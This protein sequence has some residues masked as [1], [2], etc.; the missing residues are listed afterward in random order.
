MQ[1]IKGP[2]II[3]I[4][5][6]IGGIVFIIGGIFLFG[7]VSNFSESVEDKFQVNAT[8]SGMRGMVAK[9]AA[10]ALEPVINALTQLTKGVITSLASFLTLIGVGLCFLGWGLHKRKYLA[11]VLTIIL[12]FVA[13]VIDVVA[14]GFVSGASSGVSGSDFLY[15]LI[16]V[17]AV[18]LIANAFIIYYLTKKSTVSLFRTTN[19]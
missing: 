8:G 3:A 2:S 12:M 15:A 17:L 6:I 4:A 10:N 14:L 18:H 11:W 5:I 9:T 16:A 1:L 7:G 13:I 19:T